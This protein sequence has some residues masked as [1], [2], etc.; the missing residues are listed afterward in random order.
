MYKGRLR[1]HGERSLT[2]LRPCAAESGL[3][4]FLNGLLYY[5]LH[6]VRCICSIVPRDLQK[7]PSAKHPLSSVRGTHRHKHGSV[8]KG[9]AV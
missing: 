2:L 9:A 4:G 8:S 5:S 3:S 6:F 1:F 7:L